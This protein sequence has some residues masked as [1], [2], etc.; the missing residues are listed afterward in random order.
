M[1]EADRLRTL[2]AY[3]IMDSAAERVFDDLTELAS[4]IC[5]TPISMVSLVDDK[6]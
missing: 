1:N 5:S 3:N 4:V 6:R 2:N